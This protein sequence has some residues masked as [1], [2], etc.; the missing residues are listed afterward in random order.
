MTPEGAMT[1]MPLGNHAVAL[2]PLHDNREYRP[3]IAGSRGALLEN[4]P[5]KDPA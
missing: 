1:R 5:A 3:G 2:R 4:P